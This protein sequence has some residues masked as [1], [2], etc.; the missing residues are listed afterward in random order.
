MVDSSRESVVAAAVRS[1]FTA[2]GTISL[3]LTVLASAWGEGHGERGTGE[4][5][6]GRGM[7]GRGMGGGAWGEGHGVKGT[8][9]TG[10][11]LLRRDEDEDAGGGD[12][13]A[14]GGDEDA[15]GGDEDAG[16]GDEDAGGGDEDAG[17]G[18]EDAG[19]GDE[20]AG[21]GD[22]DAGGGDE[23]AGGGDEDAGGDTARP[24]L[25]PFSPLSTLSTSGYEVGLTPLI[26]FY[27]SSGAFSFVNDLSFWSRLLP[28]T[29]TNLKLPPN[30]AP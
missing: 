26:S 19:G 2:S 4:G 14:G 1:F 6:G 5:H 11:G 22:E 12:E 30:A 3:L 21:G 20:D 18:D 10:E 13:D 16:G 24:L 17:G 15:G 29:H 27:P 8:G 23:D 9:S 28:A 25:I 7:G